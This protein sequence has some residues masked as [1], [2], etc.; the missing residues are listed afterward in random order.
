[1]PRARF[2]TGLPSVPDEQQVVERA[3]EQ[4][5][6]SC[7]AMIAPHLLTEVREAVKQAV[8]AGCIMYAQELESAYRLQME[9][10]GNRR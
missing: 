6:R 5:E 2:L 10:E 7:A 8:R 4:F 3:L 9:N 1:M